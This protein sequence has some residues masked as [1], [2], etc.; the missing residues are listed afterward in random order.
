MRQTFFSPA[1]KEGIFSA[2]Q[3]SGN[4]WK[5]VFDKFLCL[6]EAKHVDTHTASTEGLADRLKQNKTKQKDV[7]NWHDS[8]YNEGATTVV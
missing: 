7:N 1:H 2:Y 6:C 8:S 3:G 5:Y 4:L